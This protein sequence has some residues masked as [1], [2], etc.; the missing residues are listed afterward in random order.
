[1]EI[2]PRKEKYRL[3]CDHDFDTFSS[4]D[5]KVLSFIYADEGTDL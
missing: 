3:L 4:L 1:M 2:T 5:W